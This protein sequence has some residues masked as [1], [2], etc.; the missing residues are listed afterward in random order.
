MIPFFFASA[1]IGRKT[2]AVAAL[3]A[4][5]PLRKLRRDDAR[6]SEDESLI[7]SPAKNV[8]VSTTLHQSKTACQTAV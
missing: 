2:A 5:I 8:P 7:D 1:S 4:A 3:A 6:S